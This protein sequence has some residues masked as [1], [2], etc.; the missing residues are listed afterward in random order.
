MRH[1]P[2]ILP[3]K[4]CKCLF[5]RKGAAQCCRIWTTW[6]LNINYMQLRNIG[7]R[8]SCRLNEQY[9]HFNSVGDEPCAVKP[10][11]LLISL[12]ICQSLRS[13]GS[14]T[15]LRV[16]PFLQTPI[17][18][19][20]FFPPSCPYTFASIPLSYLWALCCSHLSSFHYNSLS[21][22]SPFFLFLLISLC[23]CSSTCTGVLTVLKRNQINHCFLQTEQ[24]SGKK[25]QAGRKN[26]LNIIIT[27]WWTFDLGLLFAHL[28]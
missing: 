17:S 21:S 10:R 25:K 1:F 4:T 6:V 19:A 13:H 28:D 26:S 18:C 14:D 2:F 16:L 7:N 12:A 11:W 15:L 5:W 3:L 24:F 22:V 27:G 20:L 23:M 9:L 8:V